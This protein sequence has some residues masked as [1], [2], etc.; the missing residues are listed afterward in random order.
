MF[1]LNCLQRSKSY[2]TYSSQ[3][4]AV[5]PPAL[6]PLPT[7]AALV[8]ST[9]LPTPGKAARLGQ[10]GRTLFHKVPIKILCSEFSLNDF[11]TSSLMAS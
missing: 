10:L 3:S 2:G 1:S 6:P 5:S 8:R 9:P 4:S 7:A 11:K